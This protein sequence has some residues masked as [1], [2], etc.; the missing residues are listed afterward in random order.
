MSKL[1]GIQTLA[2]RRNS[3]LKPIQ[4][5]LGSAYY[6]TDI[7]SSTASGF[8]NDAVADYSVLFDGLT[9][10][11]S[12]IDGAFNVDLDGHAVGTVEWWFN[13]IGT[14]NYQKLLYKSA[15]Y[16]FGLRD[17]GIPFGDMGDIGAVSKVDNQWHHF[18]VSWNGS[19]MSAW[20]DGVY[21]KRTA[22][23]TLPNSVDTLF[24][25]RRDTTEEFK[26]Y[27]TEFRIS[28]IARYTTLVNFTPPSARFSM[29]VN[30]KCL[31]HMNEGYGTTAT[32]TVGQHNGVLNGGTSWA[33]ISPFT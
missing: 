23:G 27:I 18:A 30:T 33:S 10:S 1:G 20:I 13:S 16:D 31:L 7:L 11:V 24:L 26:G 32:D 19:F 22:F 5:K 17:N 2:L 12:V 29:D 15:V 14:G 25:G 21:L 6:A 4:N 8:G 9:G 3:G 28:N